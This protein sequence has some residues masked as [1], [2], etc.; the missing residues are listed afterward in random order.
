[1]IESNR[2]FLYR[3]AWCNLSFINR[4]IKNSDSR[5]ITCLTFNIQ[6]SRYPCDPLFARSFHSCEWFTTKRKMFLLSRVCPQRQASIPINFASLAR[7]YKRSVFPCSRA[8]CQLF[9]ELSSLFHRKEIKQLMLLKIWLLLSL[10]F[11]IVP[12]KKII[13]AIFIYSYYHN[14]NSNIYR[15]N[16]SNYNPFTVWT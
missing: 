1:M 12:T 13:V 10:Y 4:I 9:C 8:F 5:S 2:R 14:R 3:L 6:V 16:F 7:E 11:L 15:K